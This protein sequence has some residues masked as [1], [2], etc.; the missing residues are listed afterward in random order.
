MNY[1]IEKQAF[2]V[3][4]TTADTSLK[5]AQGIVVSGMNNIYV[6]K[7]I[8]KLNGILHKTAQFTVIGQN[9]NYFDHFGRVVV[10]IV[11]TQA[12]QANNISGSPK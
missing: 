2:S 11:T 8:I 10:S 1:A 3:N 6:Q 4:L 5:I 9:H 7:I 12:C